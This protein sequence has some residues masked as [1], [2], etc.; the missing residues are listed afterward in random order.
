MCA[1]SAH[2]T[3]L[4]SRAAASLRQDGHWP[5][6]L[7]QAADIPVAQQV[8]AAGDGFHTWYDPASRLPG[9]VLF[10]RCCL[11]WAQELNANLPSMLAQLAASQRAG[12]SSS[13]VGLSSLKSLLFTL[14]IAVWVFFSRA[15]PGSPEF[16]FPPSH[17]HLL[18]D[19]TS[20]WITKHADV[21]AAAGV[22]AEGLLQQLEQLLAA[23]EVAAASTSQVAAAVVDLARELLAT[24]KACCS[25]PLKI[26]C[27]NPVCGVA[28]GPSEVKLVGGGMGLCKGCHGVR[29]CSKTCQSQHWKQHKPV[30]KALAERRAAAMAAVAALPQ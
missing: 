11:L 16:A 7:L 27:N 29:Y 15:F 19:M 20:R 9:V 28:D 10:G 3:F 2:A 4:V 30:C 24:G 22:D 17:L 12:S 13:T 18:V 5:A 23:Q 6:V 21:I 14:Y 8:S 25:V 26:L 1:T